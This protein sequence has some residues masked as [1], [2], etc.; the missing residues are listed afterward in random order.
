MTLREKYREIMERVVV[1]DEMRQ[2][3]L[4]NICSTDAVP[5]TKNNP[6]P[7][8]AEICRG[9]R[10]FCHTSDRRSGCFR[11]IPSSAGESAVS[12]PDG[13]ALAEGMH[14]ALYVSLPQNF[15][16]RS[17][18][19]S[20]ILT[21]CPLSR[22]LPFTVLCSEKLPKLIIPVRTGRV[23]LTANPAGQMTTPGSTIPLRI[24]SRY[25]PAMS[26]QQ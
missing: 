5:E 2:R 15:P 14:R 3:I 26:K 11:H 22:P 20:R 23:P 6:I 19:R 12:A 17:D 21:R 7:A 16:R 9:C 4:R 1:T 24:R 13:N 18:S 10:M 25:P 8:L